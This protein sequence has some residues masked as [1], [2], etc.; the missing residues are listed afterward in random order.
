MKITVTFE[1]PNVLLEDINPELYTILVDTEEKHNLFIKVIEE[2]SKQ[3][4]S[5]I[6]TLK[7]IR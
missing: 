5:N 1:V 4:E 7:E 6:K 3:L 2:S